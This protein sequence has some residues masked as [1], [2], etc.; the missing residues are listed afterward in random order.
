MRQLMEILPEIPHLAGLDPSRLDITRLGGLSNANYKVA[1]PGISAVVRLAGAGT[2]AYVDRTAEAHNARAAAAA[3]VA[4]EVLYSDDRR[5]LFVTRFVEGAQPLDEAGAGSHSRLARI[6]RKLQQLHQET[7]R[8]A[9]DFDPFRQLDRYVSILE[10]HRQDPQAAFLDTLAN[11]HGCRGLLAARAG[12]F[13]P[14]HC[15]LLPE[16]FLDD[17]EGL[18]IIDYEFSGNCDPLFD[19]GDFAGEANLDEGQ[20]RILL[21][22]YFAGDPPPD[23]RMLFAAYKA[24]SLLMAAGWSQVQIANGNTIEDFETYTEVRLDRCRTAMASADLPRAT[25]LATGG[26]GQAGRLRA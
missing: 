23:A 20:D 4:P 24:V 1:G 26:G 14:C 2:E 6:G 15:D 18:Y 12:A 21:E 10:S 22:S 16:N 7:G 3:G 9:T 11:L 8:F 13:K 17:G 5:G 19:L 25:A